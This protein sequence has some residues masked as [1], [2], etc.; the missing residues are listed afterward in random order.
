MSCVAEH[1]AVQSAATVIIVRFCAGSVD[2]IT[3]APKR[4]PPARARATSGGA[5]KGARAR[6]SVKRSTRGDHAHLK[7]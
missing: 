3:R 7:P 6:G 1:Q 4:R 2:A 5:P